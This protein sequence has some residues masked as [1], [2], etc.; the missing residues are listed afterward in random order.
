MH[1][2]LHSKSKIKEAIR[3]NFYILDKLR[4]QFMCSTYF[5]QILIYFFAVFKFGENINCARRKAPRYILNLS[6]CPERDKRD[7]HLGAAA[8]RRPRQ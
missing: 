4:K 8:R 1:F 2:L 5:E 6:M 7:F 3:V